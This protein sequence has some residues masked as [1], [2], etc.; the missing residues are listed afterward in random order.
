M[1]EIV[2]GPA[3]YSQHC[4]IVNLDLDVPHTKLLDD[5]LNFITNEANSLRN[6][7]SKLDEETRILRQEVRHLETK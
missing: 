1:G 5:A 3:L 4:T 6:K 2:G 7:L